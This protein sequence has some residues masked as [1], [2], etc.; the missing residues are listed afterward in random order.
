MLD[1]QSNQTAKYTLTTLN[2][3]VMTNKLY[4]ISMC[5]YEDTSEMQIKEKTHSCNYMYYQQ[6]WSVF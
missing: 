1:V 6:G 5:A 3:Q 2:T 4:Y